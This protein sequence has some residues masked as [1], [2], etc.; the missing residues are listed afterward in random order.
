MR[1]RPWPLVILA[2]LHLIAPFGN[3]LFSAYLQRISLSVY[4]TGLFHYS[5]W[6]ELAGFFF[7]W[8]LAGFAIYQIREWSYPVFLSVYLL[9]F[10][11]NYQTWRE[12]PQ[13]LNITGMITIHVV[14]MAVVGYFLI[15]AV[16]MTYFDK[17]FRWWEA[18]PRYKIDLDSEIVM[19]GKIDRGHIVNISEGGAFVE[20]R[21][22]L[23]RGI[24]GTISFQVLSRE[25]KVSFRVVHKNVSG[26]KGY[27]LEF[28]HDKAT[29][30]RMRWLAQGF[31]LL[32]VNTRDGV[33][34]KRKSF[35]IWAVRFMMTGKGSVPK[36]HNHRKPQL[37]TIA[38]GKAE[39]ATAIAQTEK[40]AKRRAS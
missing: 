26:M 13:L 27:G 24:P 29:Q 37:K 38:G 15:P 11:N 39:D 36:A 4:L 5:S 2:A 3:I 9:C 1:T 14:N 10:Y 21:A 12:F 16:R 6:Y 33:I 32:G 17:K 20:T 25:F 19:D 34:K 31:K 30:T 40:G 28:L 22:L 7:L 23:E 18:K 8:P 35:A